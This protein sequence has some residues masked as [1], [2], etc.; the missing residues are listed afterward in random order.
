MGIRLPRAL[1]LSASLL[2]ALPACGYLD[3]VV[4]SAE[5]VGYAPDGTLA[6]F[7]P[8]GITLYDAEMKSARKSIQLEKVAGTVDVPIGFD[9]ARNGTRAAVGYS[10]TVKKDVVVYAIPGGDV[11]ATIDVDMPPTADSIPVQSVVMSPDGEL[12]YVDGPASGMF[13][14]ADGTRLW[15]VDWPDEG[16]RTVSFSSDGQTVF[17][18]QHFS[19]PSRAVVDARNAVT[20]A[21][22]FRHEFA[23]TVWGLTATADGTTVIALESY[24]CP[25]D[26]SPNC[27]PAFVFR[28]TADGTLTKSIPHP[29]GLVPT[30]GWWVSSP[31]TCTRAGDLCASPATDP[32]T[33][34]AFVLVFKPEG[35]VVHQLDVMGAF[36]LAFSPDDE[37][38]AVAGGDARVFRVADGKLLSRQTYTY[39]VF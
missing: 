16:P 14:V 32:T 33:E 38:L 18:V 5:G 9:L 7:T 15:G 11:V 4:T 37:L 34:K 13:R 10:N 20:G 29:A 8:A 35:T 22:A 6:V 28:S 12:V 30:R 1:A 23:G 31:L 25:S 17:C 26:G 3:E 2:G 36:D 27:E 24:P 39:G 21:M 19:S